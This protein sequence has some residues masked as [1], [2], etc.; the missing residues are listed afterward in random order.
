MEHV[1]TGGEFL[2]QEIRVR[3]AE[4]DGRTP[5][6]YIELGAQIIAFA[7]QV[8]FAHADIA[9]WSVG[10]GEARAEGQ[11]AGRFLGHLDLDNR[12]VRAVG[13]NRLD[14]DGFEEPEVLQALLR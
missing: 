3:E 4:V 5:A 7:E 2:V 12:L 8:P 13:R 1:E 9:E 14:V 10:R 6:R 11:L